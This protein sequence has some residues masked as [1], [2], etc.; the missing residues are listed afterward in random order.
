MK[1]LG[2]DRKE[3]SENPAAVVAPLDWGLGHAA[4][5][6]PVIRELIQN[7]FRVIIAGSG[8]SLKMLQAE[9]P[10]LEFRRINTKAYT[11]SKSRFTLWKLVFQLPKFYTNIYKERR[12]AEKLYQKYTPSLIISDNR[13]GFHSKHCRSVF[14]SHQ[15]SP[16]LPKYLRFFESCIRKLHIRMIR[17]FSNCLIPDFEGTFNLSGSLSHG[18]SLSEKFRFIGTLSRFSDSDGSRENK[19]VGGVLV[20]ISGPEPQRSIFY[21]KIVAQ[22]GDLSK[23]VFV[24]AGK[25]GTA[26]EYINN[27]LHAVNHL[28]QKQ[29]SEA[30]HTAEYVICRAGYS[31]VMDLFVLRKKAVLI[32]TPGQTEQEYLAK[33]LS[34]TGMFLFR[35]QAQFNLK[36]IDKAAGKFEPYFGT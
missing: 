6:V 23:K 7:D 35:K 24:V 4:R 22:A 3:F 9:F 32:P 13:Y 34:K 36:D 11:Y 10:K 2:I 31:S 1:Y 30:I 29:M 18:F 25:P 33:H 27:N 26:F 14:I 5:C 16:Q 20:I 19:S 8:L 17:P 12:A 28:S 21:E 15:I